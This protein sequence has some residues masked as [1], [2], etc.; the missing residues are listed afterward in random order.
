MPPTLNR[1]RWTRC[2]AGWAAALLGVAALA[3]C[4]SSLPER[5]DPE[6]A[7]QA[8]RTALDAW[9]NGESIE[10]LTK[11]TPP[12]YFNDPKATDGVQL[13]S[14]EFEGSPE[15]SGQS[16]RIAVKATLQRDQRDGKER[17]LAYLVDIASA[18]VIVPE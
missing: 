12:I 6:Q 4:G 13:K 3:G 8:L 11:R 15:F 16:V 2:C 5:P 9:Q 17:S 10:D 7:K 18:I 14:Y 1:G